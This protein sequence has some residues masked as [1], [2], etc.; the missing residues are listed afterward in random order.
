LGSTKVLKILGGLVK[1]TLQYNWVADVV[2]SDDL[3]ACGE[4][5]LDAIFDYGW[6]SWGM[7]W[8][9]VVKEWGMSV[10]SKL[11]AC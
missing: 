7:I 10:A 6:N 2:N 5:M 9:L 4:M 3:S 1:R 11:N 8:A